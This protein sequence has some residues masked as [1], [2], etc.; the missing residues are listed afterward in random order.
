MK[1]YVI[2]YTRKNLGD[3]LFLDML[4]SKYPY[5]NFDISVEKIEYAKCLKRFNNV[6]IIVQKNKFKIIDIN[7]Y[8]AIVYIAGSIFMEQH[9]G[10]LKMFLYNEFIKYAGKDNLTSESGKELHNLLIE[11]KNKQK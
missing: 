9:N 4:V 11:I 7:R 1:I 3:D 10:K 6:N 5:I 8:D 2:A